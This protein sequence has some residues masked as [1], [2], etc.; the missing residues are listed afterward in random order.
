MTT[1]P[2]DLLTTNTVSE[3]I[4]EF[5]HELKLSDI[6]EFVRERAKLHALDAL[7]IAL[8]SSAMDFGQSV[9]RAASRL[10]GG[11]GSHSIGFGTPLPPASAALANGTLIHGLDFDDT[12]IEAIYHATAPALAAALAV[13]EDEH[14][15]GRQRCWPT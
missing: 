5:V 12:H 15:E 6:P 11:G 9:N 4:A 14:A 7:G 1:V 10:G 13:G 2:V 3:Q 8:A